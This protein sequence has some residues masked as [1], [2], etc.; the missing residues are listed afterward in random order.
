M[1]TPAGVGSELLLLATVQRPAVT[2][3]EPTLGPTV[4]KTHVASR[5]QSAVQEPLLTV[6][7]S[8]NLGSVFL[9]IMA[10]TNQ[11]GRH[12]PSEFQT[13]LC[14]CC[15]DIG[16]CCFGLWC[17]PCLGCSIASAMDECC[18]CGLGVPIRAVYRTK[19][20]IKGSL[21]AGHFLNGCRMTSWKL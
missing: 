21:S 6:S 4:I 7:L 8:F 3:S 11:P 14:D 10:V 13:G 18:L 1:Q 20:N 16:T 9:L 15:D 12:Q 19:Y 17:Y 2:K 5:S